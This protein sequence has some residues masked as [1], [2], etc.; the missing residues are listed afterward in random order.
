MVNPSKKNFLVGHLTYTGGGA[1][2]GSEASLFRDNWV[3]DRK[4]EGIDVFLLGH[5]H[6]QQ[7][8]GDR[9]VYAGSPVQI[10]LG[11]RDEE[12]GEMPG[13]R[14]RARGEPV[15]VLLLRRGRG[16]RMLVL[17]VAGDGEAPAD[18]VSR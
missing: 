12:K 10:D 9:V 18:V 1:M 15:G 14:A 13:V 11:E 3:V 6:R 4:I 2:S 7:N 17:L 16:G 8:I 5:V